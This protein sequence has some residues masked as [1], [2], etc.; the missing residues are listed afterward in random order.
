MAICKMKVTS[1]L[2]CLFQEHAISFTQVF[3]RTLGRHPFSITSF[4][5]S[6]ELYSGWDMLCG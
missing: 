2:L 4:S 5:V 1:V 3:L 6:G